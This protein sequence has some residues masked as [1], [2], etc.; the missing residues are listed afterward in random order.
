MEQQPFK[1]KFT[2]EFVENNNIVAKA[3][4]VVFPM[5]RKI[6]LFEKEKI[7]IEAIE[8]NLFKVWLKFIPIVNWFIKNDFEIHLD[9]YI[10][11]IKNEP[12]WKQ[13]RILLTVNGSN[14]VIYEHTGGLK[15]DV[16]SIY[17]DDKQIGLVSKNIEVVWGAQTYKGLFHEDTNASINRFLMVFIDV[18]WNEHDGKT[19]ARSKEY[20]WGWDSKLGKPLN[21]NWKVNERI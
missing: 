2:Y 11:E 4:K 8:K 17:Q 15:G 21:E 20:S 3:D 14:Y 1:W 6:M 5:K 19:Y 7:I 10:G 9:G 18:F 12:E 16:Y 13:R